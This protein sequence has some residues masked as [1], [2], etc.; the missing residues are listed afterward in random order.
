MGFLDGFLVHMFLVK[1]EKLSGLGVDDVDM[2]DVDF[3]QIMCYLF[4]LILLVLQNG[5]L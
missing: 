5:S 1:L 3:Y 4:A 2:V